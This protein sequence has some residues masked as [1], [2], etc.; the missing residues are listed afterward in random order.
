MLE[1]D[2]EVSEAARQIVQRRIHVVHVAAEAAGRVFVGDVVDANGELNAA[3]G[4]EVRRPAQLNVEVV[5]G[6]Q[7]LV[8]I[9]LEKRSV[10]AVGAGFGHR[11]HD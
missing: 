2:P 7:L 1:G 6:V 8:S 5:D 11:V 3:I 4:Y 9:E 10:E